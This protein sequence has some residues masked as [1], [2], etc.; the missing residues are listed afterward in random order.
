MASLL[1]GDEAACRELCARI[2]AEHANTQDANIADRAAKTCL[3]APNSV[4]DGETV[5]RLADSSIKSQPDCEWFQLVKGMATYRAGRNEE[6]MRWLDGLRQQCNTRIAIL[7]GYF[8]AMAQKQS[9]NP[10]S[11]LTVLNTANQ[12][13]DEYLKQG[14]LGI[15]AGEMW[16]FNSAAAILI[17][18]EAE[19]MILG[20][21]TS[22]R[23]TAASLAA[24]RVAWLSR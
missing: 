15:P 9:G 6:A 8:F 11:A 20:A 3:L 22:P 23:P 18:A 7:A 17:R 21:E 2:I 1:A 14:N 24:A 5:Q 16:W 13:L 19:R 12:E 10:E 4:A